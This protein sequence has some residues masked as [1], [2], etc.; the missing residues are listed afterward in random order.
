MFE[1]KTS[2]AIN[3]K[4]PYNSQI[5]YTPWSES[6]S[7][8][9]IKVTIIKDDLSRPVPKTFSNVF[10]V[11]SKVS[12]NVRTPDCGGFIMKS[13]AH[14]KWYS[15][16]VKPFKVWRQSMTTTQGIKVSCALFWRL[17]FAVMLWTK[18]RSN[19][20]FRAVPTYMIASIV[21]HSVQYKLSPR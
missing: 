5:Y 1:L 4:N 8:N 12:R 11:I 18:L 7:F 20:H 3:F 6:Q 21:E 17:D 2:P 9:R 15:L 14:Q 16:R 10:E 13:D 19:A